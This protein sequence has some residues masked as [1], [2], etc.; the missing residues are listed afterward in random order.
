MDKIKHNIFHR[1]LCVT[2]NRLLQFIFVPVILSFG[3]VKK[4]GCQIN[5]SSVDE[6]I[7]PFGS[8]RFEHITAEQGE[9]RGGVWSILQEKQGFMWFGT[10]DG[11]YRYDGYDFKIFRHN[12]LDSSSISNNFI[13][14]I[15]EYK[16]GALWVGTF[17]GGL[18]ICNRETQSFHAFKNKPDDPNSLSNDIILSFFEDE[19]GVMWTGTYGGGLNKM[20][21]P[22]F[23]SGTNS[24]IP[25]VEFVRYKIEPVGSNDQNHDVV[26]CIYQDKV[27]RMWLGT[28][29]GLCLFDKITGHSICYKKE[30]GN[31]TGL[32]NSNVYYVHADMYGDLWI[33]TWGGGL[34]KMGLPKGV[35]SIGDLKK[36][37][38]TY[39]HFLN[40]PDN[41]KSISDNH[42]YT[43]YRDRSNVLWIGTY[44]GGLN[45]I[46]LPV[47]SV[48]VS[49]SENTSP[50]FIRFTHQSDDPNSLSNDIVTSIYED[51]SENMW[52][53]TKRGINKIKKDI[54]KFTLLRNDPDDPG[55]LS[56]NNIRSIFEDIAGNLWIGTINGLNRYN[57]ATRKTSKT[58]LN[59]FSNTNVHYFND[60]NK[61][62]RLS[63]DNIRYICTDSTGRL[64][65]GTLE[66]IN[67]LDIATHKITI[68]KHDST[69]TN[70]LSGNIV[71]FIFQDSHGAMWI[72]T[73]NGLNRFD[74]D[75][76][77]FI[78]YKHDAGNPN[79]LSNNIVWAIHED[80]EESIWIGTYGGGLNRFDRE[81]EVFEHFT[82]PDELPDNTIYGILED[83]DG[84]LWLSTNHGISKVIKK[85]AD[86]VIKGRTGG[87]DLSFINYN[88]D[89]GL[90][91]E[92]FNFN[93]YSRT[94]NGNMFF[95]G[96]NG[97]TVFHSDSISAF[98]IKGDTL[99]PTV[100]ITDFQVLFKSVSVGDCNDGRILL[101]KSIVETD[102]IRL[103]NKDKFISFKFAALDFTH[104]EK[105]EYKYMI[106]G[107]ATEWIDLGTK[108]TVDFSLSPGDYV[109]RV[110]GSNNYG[111]WND[112]DASI[113]IIV[114]PP[115]WRTWWFLSVFTANL[116]LFI[117]I[118]YRRRIN[119]MESNKK[120]LELRAAENTQAAEDLK[121]AL[122]EVELLKNR[123]EAENI[124]L[125]DE[126]KLD[127][128]FENII[129]R[130]K[131]LK[132]VLHKVE[133]VASTD[134]TVL[135][136][137]ESGTGKELLAR[138]I[139]GI[140][141]R[142]DRPLIKVNCSA[143]PAN[144]IES[145]LFG[146]EKGS[147]TGA[148]MRKIG[149]FELADGGT[150]FLDEIG[151]LPLESQV[152]LLRFLQD[153]EFERLGNSHTKKVNVRV[154]AATNRDLQNGIE[155]GIFRK[156][157]YFRLNV[158]PVTIPP[159]RER[160][161][162]IPLL[163]QHFMKKYSKKIGKRIEAV[164]KSVIDTLLIYPWPGNVREL[165]NIIERAVIISPNKKL[166]LGDWF[167][168]MKAANGGAT[169]VTLEEIEKQHILNVLETTDWRVSGERGAAKILGL[170]RT[171]LEAR[172]KK[173]NI[174]RIK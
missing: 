64:W 164:P 168:K 166:V 25:P 38:P 150:L 16:Q 144:L 165:E 116:L 70:S 98:E 99:P 145:E 59:E 156:D 109:F 119:F 127:H 134:S 139:H 167:T 77:R 42:I 5:D 162:D 27:G 75:T 10:D 100:V 161:E 84:N 157:L 32:S 97:F 90:E 96:M 49:K 30:T 11:L 48:S 87:P 13:F 135:I 28:N 122:S 173:L 56:D 80:R 114:S 7:S 74:R 21:L 39:H 54:H 44:G 91:N 85:T 15:H 95:G 62:I 102:E 105:N 128:N 89:Q 86:A 60:L 61:S 163:V 153:G 158:F 79:S 47:P 174:R 26:H 1:L 117:V 148:V 50:S 18:N 142:K 68:L 155:E 69:N 55:S 36:T 126:I 146:H 65:I 37:I 24:E 121:N 143:L 58:D 131:S 35:S 45:K 92:E 129:T 20:V 111:I 51:K 125:Q 9:P 124:Y 133:Q 132:K 137:G 46:V 12:P 83:D 88:K 138:A 120:E 113:R 22:P 101:N 34:N 72:G 154:I 140:S 3:F 171:T 103:S 110:K 104:S 81:N 8:I 2:G 108:R 41:P 147:F 93:A 6:T 130:S 43:I 63:N 33:G 136:L 159:L 57:S 40:D 170:K 66:G 73:S 78:A 4:S 107:L 19:D 169:L 112:K 17:S 152:K 82:K 31:K 160:I 151:D 52:V 53:G 76:E 115:I 14:K 71:R 118:I 141:G 94:K 172:M 29:G 67:I 123:L 106:E 149:R 23:N